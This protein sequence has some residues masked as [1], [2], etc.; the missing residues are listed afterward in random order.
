M[1]QANERQFEERVRAFLRGES[2]WECL[3]EIGVGIEISE[4]SIEISN[5]SGQL[6]VARVSDVAAGLLRLEPRFQDLRVW[7]SVLHSAAFIDLEERFET[8]P[9]GDLL[10]EALWDAAFG[11]RPD[12]SALEVAREFAGSD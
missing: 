6:V 2:S 1:S 11:N 10:L 8:D 12:S 5:P 7:A 9:R 3:R 4:G